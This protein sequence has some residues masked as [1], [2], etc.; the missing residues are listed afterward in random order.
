MVATIYA[1]VSMA[2]GGRRL[3]ANLPN[4]GSLRRPRAGI[5]REYEITTVE[6][7]QTVLSS[8]GYFD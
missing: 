1:R 7:G 8:A 2:M 5:V 3:T 6:A 4:C